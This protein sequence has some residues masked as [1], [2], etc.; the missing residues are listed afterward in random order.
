MKKL[1]ALILVL[2]IAPLACAGLA[3]SVDG[4]DPGVETSVAVGSHIVLDI[5]AYDGELGKPVWLSIDGPGIMDGTNADNL[6]QDPIPGTPD[7]GVWIIDLADAVG[8]AQTYLVDVLIPG[9]EIN[10]LPNGKIA[11]LIDFQC[12]GLGDVTVTIQH[13]DT[14]AVM[15]TLIIHQIPEPASMALLALGGLFL[16]RRK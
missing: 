3:I 9:S 5:T 12:L 13:G 11:D 7:F 14:G 1:A 15:D 16:R 4:A 10:I 8:H 2:G 6:I